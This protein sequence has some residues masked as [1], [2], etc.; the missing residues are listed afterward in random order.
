MSFHEQASSAIGNKLKLFRREP[1]RF[2]TRAILA[3]VYFTIIAAFAAAT[4]TLLDSSAP[5]WG[6]YAFGVIF[7]SALYIIIF[8]QGELAT[9]GMMFISYVAISR[10]TPVSWGAVII[11]YDTI[12]NV[13]GT[14]RTAFAKLWGVLIII[15]ALAY[16]GYEHSI[17]N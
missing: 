16:M 11:I 7:A 9:G 1:Q 10:K 17:A 13:L 8:L 4:A 6:K 12:F 14:L 5:G 3:G 15:P 2:A